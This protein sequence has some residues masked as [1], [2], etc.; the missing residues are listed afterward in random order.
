MSSRFGHYQL[1]ST[2]C[3]RLADTLGDT[4]ETVISVH[5]LRQ[6]LCRAYVAGSPSQFDGAIIQALHLP[7][8]PTGFGENAAA[9][10][11]LLQG[12]DGWDCVNVTSTCAPNLGSLIE[13]RMRTTVRYYG[14]IHHTLQQPVILFHHRAVRQL[15]LNDL[16]LLEAASSEVRGSAFGST[17]TLLTEGIAAA[18]I[19]ENQI[20]AIAHTSALS[21]RHADIGISTLATWRGHGFA[22]AAAS[23]VAHEVQ[24]AGQMPVWS[25][26]E[27]NYASLRV[28]QKLGFTR[29][30]ERTYVIVDSKR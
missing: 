4:P 8:E 22:S 11:D 18:A 7:G 3:Q 29:V 25:T 13:M 27:N 5:L 12:V 19:V 15:T 14:D 30:A 9:L 28:A 10:W 16:A 23:I 1:N 6:G 24:K 17:R 20:V 21:Q 26:G 2:E